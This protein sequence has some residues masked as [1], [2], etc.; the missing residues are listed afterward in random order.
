MI[1]PTLALTSN[2]FSHSYKQ[3]RQDWRDKVYKCISSLQEKLFTQADEL[4]VDQTERGP[5]NETLATDTLWLG[6]KDA[7]HVGIILSATH[8]I[9]GYVG[10]AVQ[11]FLLDTLMTNHFDIPG[12][13]A[14][15][16]VHA[17]NP[18]GMAWK[19]RCDHM[20]VDLNRNY[21]DF[22]S[23][24]E[25]RAYLTIQRCLSIRDREERQQALK[26]L[27]SNM[28]QTE[29]EVAL[30]GGQYDDPEGPF[31]GGQCPA[32]GQQVCRK[33]AAGFDLGERYLALIDIHSGLGAWSLGELISDHPLGNTNDLIARR[34]FGAGVTN[35]ARGDSSSVTKFGLQDYFWHRLMRER[36]YYLTLE[37]GSYSTS[38]LFNVLIDDHCLWRN[39]T[40]P[41]KPLLLQ[42]Q[43]IMM[44]HF[45]PSDNYWRQLVLIQA[46]QVLDRLLKGFSA[47]H[48]QRY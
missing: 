36:G 2:Y 12:D 22:N 18:W 29:Y 17:L 41:P 20:G 3:A 4:R 45:A 19:R 42:Q 43:A 38:D 10:S 30:S 40:I 15:L 44:E 27:A 31:Y 24:P 14:L 16:F 33:L 39:K 6:P 37:Y 23:P 47:H 5:E 32:H 34:L 8:G 25:N 46:A 48:D 35:P 21:I 28:S 7:K 11:Q 13:S 1:H 26:K 9:E